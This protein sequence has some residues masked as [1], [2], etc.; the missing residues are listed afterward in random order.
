MYALVLTCFVFRLNAKEKTSKHIE[1]YRKL[2]S[3][4][5]VLA[6]TRL[7]QALETYA[8]KRTHD[9]KGV[10]IPSQIR[11]LFLIGD[12]FLSGGNLFSGWDIPELPEKALKCCAG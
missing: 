1:T 7:S 10:T 5:E 11:P 9:G 4:A 2:E 8:K 12:V 3:F 6:V